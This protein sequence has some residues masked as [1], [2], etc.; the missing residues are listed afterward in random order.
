MRTLTTPGPM[1]TTV[2]RDTTIFSGTSTQIVGLTTTLTT[3]GTKTVF[4]ATQSVPASTITETK[5]VPIV[6]HGTV[7]ETKTPDPEQLVKLINVPSACSPRF[8][9]TGT[10]WSP[11]ADEN[12][13]DLYR[14]TPVIGED[15]KD[16]QLL[17]CAAC[18]NTKGCAIFEFKLGESCILKVVNESAPGEKEGWVSGSCPNGQLEGKVIWDG[19]VGGVGVGP[20]WNG[21]VTGFGGR[22]LGLENEV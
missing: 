8:L 20:C 4:V 10:S 2:H 19:A 5:T 1:A 11:L 6:T 15:V 13:N 22:A 3:L 21:E 14:S 12:G 18:F 17:C 7:T 16:D 9:L